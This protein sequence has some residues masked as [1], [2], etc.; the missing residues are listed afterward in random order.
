[1]REL[2]PLDHPT[3]QRAPEHVIESAL[4]RQDPN[5]RILHLVWDEE[6]GFPEHAWGYEQWSVRP[7]QVGQGCDGTIECN[8]HYTA[9]QVLPQ[10]GVDYRAAYAEAYPDRQG[11]DEWPSAAYAAVLARETCIPPVNDATL[12]LLL[13]DIYDTNHRSLEDV[14]RQKLEALGYFTTE[15]AITG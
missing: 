12:E 9:L 4:T 11:L 2:L 7:Y 15:P 14:L 10:I 5:T 1:M 13:H 6:G 3:A 8:M